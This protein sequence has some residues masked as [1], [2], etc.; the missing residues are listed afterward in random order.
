M[1]EEKKRSRRRAKKQDHAPLLLKR[2]MPNGA[3]QKFVFVTYQLLLLILACAVL[4]F[5]TLLL[6]YANFSSDIF[7][8]YLETPLTIYVNFI[9]PTAICLALFVLIGKA[10]IAFLITVIVCLGVAIGNYY[11][12]IIRN[13]PLQFEDLTC[14][15]EALA[16]TDKQGYELNLS[17]NLVVSVLACIAMTCMLAFLTRWRLRFRWPRLI[18]VALA[19]LILVYA[20]NLCKDEVVFQNTKNYNHIDSWST[21]QIYLSRGV[22]YSFTRTALFRAGVPDNYDEQKTAADFAQY[23]DDDIP[24]DR[25]VDVIVIMRESYADL[26]DL[27]SEPGAIDFC[28]YD[29]YHALA[30]ESMTGCLVTNAFGGDTKNAERCFLTGNYVLS[31]WRKPVNSYVWYLR[32]QG[33]QTDGAH[34]FNGWFYNRRN[35]NR[36]LGFESYRFREDGF[37]ELEGKSDTPVND[38]I[39]Y[40]SIWSQLQSHD[41]DRPYFHFAVTYEGHGPYHCLRNDYPGTYFIRRYVGSYDGTAMNNYLACCARRDEELSGFVDR[42][43][44]SDRPI[45]LLTF[46]DH[47]AT[48]GKDSS[49]GT[50]SAYKTYGMDLSGATETGFLNYYSTEYLIW[51]NDAAKARLGKDVAGVT[52]PTV[53]PCYLMNVLFDTLEWGDGPAYLQTMREEMALFPI[54]STKGRVSIDGSLST[55]IPGHYVEAYRR[56][57]SLCYYWRTHFFYREVK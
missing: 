48:L 16:I 20:N 22:L 4:T 14:I 53:S 52:G 29:A 5:C 36:Y 11:L 7:K 54:M 24:E 23:Q 8:T 57:Q 40:D 44:S 55:T 13:D 2:S 27:D 9:I 42:L 1:S 15:R 43:R 17:T 3:A 56:M 34:P 28:C 25:K 35:V 26:S 10:W 45:V 32:G 41:P 50:I 39:L 31:N 38:A 37:E 18:G 6:S 33:Y 21:T 19:A 46:G 30:A 47:K 12:V 49:S 51:M